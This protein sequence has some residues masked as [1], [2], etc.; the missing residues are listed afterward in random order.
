LI[1]V[2]HFTHYTSFYEKYQTD[3]RKI[4]GRVKVGQK[5][6][7]QRRMVD[8]ISKFFLTSPNRRITILRNRLSEEQFPP[9]G[10]E[11]HTP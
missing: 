5:G 3:L 10:Q 2:T 8:Q 1:V 6:I 4:V 9:R 7:K 11:K